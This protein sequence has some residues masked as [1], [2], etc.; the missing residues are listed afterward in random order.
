VPAG[1]ECLCTR[2]YNPVCG[3]DGTTYPN[4]CQANC[5]GVAVASSAECGSTPIAVAALAAPAPAPAPEPKPVPTPVLSDLEQ[6]PRPP[7][8]AG[9]ATQL[10]G[11]APAPGDCLCAA[12]FDPVCGA[13][14]VNYPN[15][16]EARCAGTTVASKGN[17]PAAGTGGAG[18]GCL[19]PFVYAPV[20]TAAGTRSNECVAACAG[21]TTLYEGE[22]TPAGAVPPK[23]AVTTPAVPPKPAVTTPAAATKPAVATPAEPA[24]AGTTA[25]L[26][27]TALT[28][29]VPRPAPGAAG[30][31]TLAPAAGT[32]AALS[33]E[34]PAEVAPPGT[35]VRSSAV[36]VRAG[37][38]ILAGCVA[39]VTALLL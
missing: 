8:P 19:C 24:V 27:A 28:P 39:A 37:A 9:G 5:A 17:C 20:C 21:E 7:A 34:R 15:G 4:E 35:V 32:T 18:A 1:E 6:L 31:P 12:V 38:A 13:N 30:S 11:A 36:E 10:P 25:E 22:C 26:P 16:C 3:A 29:A 2:Q 23:P 14:G 33:A